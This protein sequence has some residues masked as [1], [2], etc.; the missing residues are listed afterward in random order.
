M[1]SK[2]K[3][4]STLPTIKEQQPLDKRKPTY[5]SR[6]ESSLSILT[7]RFIQF[8]MEAK[9][10]HIDLKQAAINLN[11]QKRR[12]YDITNVLE[13]IQLIEKV[14]K[15][16]VKWIGSKIREK[17]AYSSP[18]SS[19]TSSSSSSSSC[20]YNKKKQKLNQLKKLNMELENENQKLN[21]IYETIQHH[22][23]R[24]LQHPQCYFTK[25]DYDL[26]INSL[27]SSPTNTTIS[28][29]STSSS[30][31]SYIASPTFDHHHSS[32]SP[33][34]SSS[35]SSL[36]YKKEFITPTPSSQ[37]NFYIYPSPFNTTHTITT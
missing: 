31:S 37:S 6:Q 2:K 9:G 27:S 25:E 3:K 22:Q 11:V 35:S 15:N 14:S 20:Y 16:H 36:F 17:T 4:A 34:S 5:T 32:S 26:F 24:A 28:S 8:I 12:I 1:I 18:S 29:T 10:E 23:L 19:S 30:S 13:G 33:S 21:Q 7:E